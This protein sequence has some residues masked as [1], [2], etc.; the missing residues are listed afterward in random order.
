MER[1]A[2]LLRHH[3]GSRGL[4]PAIPPLSSILSR[5]EN[6]LLT[7]GAR[8][9]SAE[10]AC[11]VGDLVEH[12]HSG[13]AQ[14]VH[15]MLHPVVL[16]PTLP[17]QVLAGVHLP[18]VRADRLLGQDLNRP[19]ELAHLIPTPVPA[20]R[21]EDRL[22]LV[23]EKDAAEPIWEENCIRVHFY[24][25]ILLP[26]LAALQQPVPAKGEHGDVQP[27]A[28]HR[29]DAVLALAYS[30]Q[31]LLPSVEVVA[32]IVR[33]DL[34]GLLADHGVVV[35]SEDAG[36]ARELRL[37]Q[38][39]VA[40]I[41]DSPAEER[42]L[43]IRVGQ[44]ALLLLLNLLGLLVVRLPLDLREHHRGRVRAEACT[45]PTCGLNCGAALRGHG[46]TGAEQQR[47]C[48]RRSNRGQAAPPS[49][50]AQDRWRVTR[51][52]VHIAQLWELLQILQLRHDVLRTAP[53]NRANPSRAR[54]AVA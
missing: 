19:E 16:A 14:R 5:V 12:A 3:L 9:A 48:Q 17:R 51:R 52:R 6:N 26:D 36:T 37:D 22:A 39:N 35:A 33:A 21:S 7:V 41:H 8:S 34:H 31:V 43:V 45:R 23:L 11:I 53:H 28:G 47:S 49:G 32:A 44:L 42:R 13:D 10:R 15:A 38:V 50:E 29:I 25:E 54:A 40:G 4:L 24:R 18:L 20:I 46:S 2:E 1:D 27:R 30:G